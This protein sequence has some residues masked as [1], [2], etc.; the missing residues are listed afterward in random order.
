VIGHD[1][2]DGL[3]TV[4]YLKAHRQPQNRSRWPLVADALS[5]LCGAIVAST[6]PVPPQVFPIALGYFSGLFVYAAATDLLPRAQQLPVSRSVPIVGLGVIGMF[7]V[8]RLA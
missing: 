2:S 4:S 6:V 8:T 3:G 5:P 7:L 1:F